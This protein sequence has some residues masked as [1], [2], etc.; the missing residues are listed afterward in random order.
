MTTNMLTLFCL[1]DGESTSF[2]VK[3]ESTET[4]GD[5]KDEIKRKMT[6]RF[7][8]VAADEERVQT[9]WAD[10]PLDF[11]HRLYESMPK[12]IKEVLRK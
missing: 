4:I 2:P 1:V 9:I 7:D 12:R 10:I 6:P 11:L 3:I 8:D 5:L